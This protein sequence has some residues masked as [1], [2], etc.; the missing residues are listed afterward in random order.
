MSNLGKANHLVGEKSLYLRQHARNPV[1]WYPW[2]EEAFAK[3]RAEDKPIFL[4]I[5]YSACHWC[6]VMAHE[7]FEDD[8]VADVLNRSFVC[9]KVDREERPDIDFIYMLACQMISGGGG[10]P[11]TIVATSDGKP[12]FAGT[13]FRKGGGP[14]GPGLIDILMQLDG[15]WRLDRSE[16]LKRAEEAAKA[17]QEFSS[18]R[19]P[20]VL[21]TEIGDKA[22]QGLVRAYDER[23]GG[24][25]IAPKFPT[26]HRLTFLLR[27]WSRTTEGRALGM[28]TATLDA[29][30]RGGINDQVGYGFHRYS[31]DQRWLLPHFEKMLYDQALQALAFAEAYAATGE[32]RFKKTASNVLSFVDREMSSPFGGFFS[33]IGADSEAEEGKYYVW[34]YDEVNSLMSGLDQAVFVEAYDVQKEGNFRDEA[35]RRRTGKNVLHRANLPFQAALEH[36]LDDAVVSSMLERGLARLFEAR[37]R[38]TRPDVDDKI[39]ADWNGLMIAAYA[40]CGRA[41]G[42]EGMVRQ[43]RRGAD[44]VLGQMSYGKSRLYHRHVAGQAAIPGFL[45]DYAFMAWGLTEL[46]LTTLRA[47][48]LRSALDLT[49]VMIEHFLDRSQG[50]FYFTA[51]DGEVLLGRSKGVYDGALPSGNSMAACLLQ[52]LSRLTGKREYAELAREVVGAFAADLNANP[53]AHAQMLQAWQSLQGSPTTVEL[54]GDL[55]EVE[56]RALLGSL[57]GRYDPDLLVL[58]VDSPEAAELTGTVGLARSEDRATAYIVRGDVVSPPFTDPYSLGSALRRELE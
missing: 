33:A 30:S 16:V 57:A 17:L 21:E 27:H 15:K 31:T 14:E 13:Y 55:E 54:I 28:V 40:Y 36:G 6:H 26:P 43:A 46:Y 58:L 12:F 34:R 24:F 35:S 41:L 5:G 11:L 18:Y 23:Y 47:R 2:G 1:D 49:D 20:G 53:M 51:D 39:L 3:A 19:E 37:E 29:M 22:F 44:F 8:Y 45:D 7:S 48:Y 52:R 38:R 42:D 56:T 50:G 10:W 32:D 4:S 25:E 9:I